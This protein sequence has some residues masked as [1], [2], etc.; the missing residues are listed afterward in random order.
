MTEATKEYISWCLAEYR[1]NGFK[2]LKKKNTQKKYREITGKYPD[3]ELFETSKMTES[4]FE[5]KK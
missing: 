5:L 2:N 1:D 3:V 4:I